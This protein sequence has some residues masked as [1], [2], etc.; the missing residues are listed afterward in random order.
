MTRAR[1]HLVAASTGIALLLG[2]CPATLWAQHSLPQP[3]KQTRIMV[4]G[5]NYSAGAFKKLVFGNVELLA[6]V[7]R[8]SIVLPGR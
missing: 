5:A 6:R 1:C 3:T 4:A 2:L 7:G 8:F